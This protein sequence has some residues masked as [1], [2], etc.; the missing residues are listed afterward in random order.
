[1]LVSVSATLEDEQSTVH[2]AGSSG[3]AKGRDVWVVNMIFP[4]IRSTCSS[5]ADTSTGVIEWLKY[6]VAAAAEDKD[7]E[8]EAAV[9]KVSSTCAV[10]G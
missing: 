5:R 1:M 8:E 6:G 2:T 10:D 9:D 4:S 7:E 3:S